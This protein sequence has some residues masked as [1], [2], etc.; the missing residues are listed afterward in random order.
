[1]ERR[2]VIQLMGVSALALGGLSSCS[3]PSPTTGGPTPTARA[4]LRIPMSSIPVGGGII[5]AADKVVITQAT[6]GQYR[7]FSAVCQHQGCI[8][9]SIQGNNIICPC[10]G[11]R[12][13]IVD[14]SV[15]NG[16]TTRPLIPAKS[17][18]ADGTDLVVVR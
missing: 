17:V 1:M 10:H 14:G 13:S 6:A 11:S 9:D 18:I 12:Y 15:V 7:A 2:A 5:R 16:P 3:N 8:V 4:G